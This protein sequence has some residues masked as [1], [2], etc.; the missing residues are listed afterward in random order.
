MKT[1]IIYYNFLDPRGNERKVGGVETYL[2]NLASLIAQ[3]GSEPILFQAA[4]VPFERRLGPV[5]VVGVTPSGLMKRSIKRDL[6][7]AAVSRIDYGKDVL[8]FGSDNASVPAHNPKCISIQHGVWWDLPVRFLRGGL[9]GKFL[10]PMLQ[11]R[12]VASCAKRNFANCPNRVCVD[13]NFLNWYRTQTAEEPDGNIWVIPNFVD[14]PSGFAAS[15][16]RPWREPVKI[17]FARRFMEFRGSRLM[18]AVF[19]RLLERHPDIRIAFAGEGPDEGRFK[20]QFGGDPR[21]SITKYAANDALRIHLQ[22]DIAVVPSL[23]SEGTS[24]SLAEAMAAGC[25]VVATNVGGMT[26]MV[27][28]GY[29]GRLVSPRVDD[30]TRALEDL[31]TKP[32][33]RLQLGRKAADTARNAFGLERWKQAWSDV[34]AAVEGNGRMTGHLE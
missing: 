17:I 34:L 22:Y 27:I 21:V 25:A 31:I 5:T 16:P 4:E 13:Y 19:G 6:F 24:L 20:Q 15:L 9:T 30:L 2:W 3:R 26:N 32:E 29:N 28:D 1:A 7:R 33:R 18:A 14:V 10:S 23:A 12:W 11:K 8:I